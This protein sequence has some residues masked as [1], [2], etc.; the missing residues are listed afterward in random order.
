MCPAAQPDGHDAPR[1]IDETV[2]R[3][4]G[5]VEDIG[6]GFEDPVRQPVLAHELPDILDR[7]ELGTFR[8]QQQQGDV[9]RHDERFGP[10]P[11]RLIEKQDGVRARRD[12]GG[13]LR[14]VQGHPL[15][16]ASWQH[17]CGPLALS[18]ADRPI[19]IG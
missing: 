7:V 14:Q 6:I 2:R 19:N 5:V 17:E 4:A 15:R 18:R 1:L 16:V 9:G 3:E 8:R 13:Y 10:K 12:G 11:F